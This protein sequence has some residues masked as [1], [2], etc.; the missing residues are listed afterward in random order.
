MC[1][2][3]S[4]MTEQ[5]IRYASLSLQFPRCTDA[6]AISVACLDL[7]YYVTVHET[8]HHAPDK[9]ETHSTVALSNL[10]DNDGK[11][12]QLTNHVDES[13]LL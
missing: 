7:H 2:F 11:E 6:E 4:I 5:P 8:L 1:T 9:K 13:T 12:L 3:T 10:Q